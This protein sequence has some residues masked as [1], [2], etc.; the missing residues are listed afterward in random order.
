MTLF[1]EET[2]KPHTPTPPP[3]IEVDAT[4]EE[5]VAI[6]QKAVKL[7]EQNPVTL[8]A[9]VCLQYGVCLRWPMEQSV[10]NL[11]PLRTHCSCRNTYKYRHLTNYLDS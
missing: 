1:V 4:H 2:P 9:E 3:E 5:V 7:A 11:F 10:I 6:V 8:S